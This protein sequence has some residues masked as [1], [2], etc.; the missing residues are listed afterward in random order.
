MIYILLVQNTNLQKQ[1]AFEVQGICIIPQILI[2][3]VYK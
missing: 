2:F 3:Q 1:S